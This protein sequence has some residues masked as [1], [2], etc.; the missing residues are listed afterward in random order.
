MRNLLRRSLV[1]SHYA[2]SVIGPFGVSRGCVPVIV[3][4]SALGGPV[5]V[6]SL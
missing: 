2:E 3:I 1:A 4:S 6:V 5:Q